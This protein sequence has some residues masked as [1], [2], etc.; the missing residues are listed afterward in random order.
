MSSTSS[1]CRTGSFRMCGRLTEDVAH[2]AL[3]RVD[4]YTLTL[5][6]KEV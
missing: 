6:Y 2:N 5:I 3:S 4:L 1:V